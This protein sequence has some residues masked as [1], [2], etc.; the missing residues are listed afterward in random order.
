ME[1][2]LPHVR[3]YNTSIFK[4]KVYLNFF[5]GVILQLVTNKRSWRTKSF[6]VVRSSSFLLLYNTT[7]TLT[8]L[9]LPA[10]FSGYHWVYHFHRCCNITTS[11]RKN[12]ITGVGLIFKKSD[13][14]WV[15]KKKFIRSL[16]ILKLKAY[17]EKKRKEKERK[18]TDR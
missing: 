14:K 12:N 11:T 7:L 3:I 9:I 17:G 13:C 15:K 1:P 6:H 4:V 10:F 5:L 8:R 16:Y 18:K 2:S